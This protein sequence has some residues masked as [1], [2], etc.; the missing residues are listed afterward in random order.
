[1]DPETGEEVFFHGHPSWLSMVSFYVKGLLAAVIVGVLAGGVIPIAA[2]HVQPAGWSSLVLVVY[3]RCCRPGSLRRV[4][5]TYTVSDERLTI[6]VGLLSRDLHQTRLERVQNVNLRQSLLERIL[7]G[8][9]RLRHRRGVRVTT[10][11]STALRTG[12]RSSGPSTR[13]CSELQ[14]QWPRHYLKASGRRLGPDRGAPEPGGRAQRLRLVGPLPGEVGVLAAEVAVR[15]GLLVDRAV[16]PQ[17]LAEGAGPQVEM[18]VD[19]LQD[20]PRPIFS[21]PKVST[22]TDTG[23]ATP[24]A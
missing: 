22:I 3:W 16:E 7:R 12:A 6:H 8:L 2:G 19:E 1:M 24:I 5:T 14:L 20:L 11:S 4:S 10:S 17:V 13:R 23:C 18:L 15:R 21:V 9:G